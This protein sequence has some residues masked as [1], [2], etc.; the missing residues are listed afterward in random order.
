[1]ISL[2]SL[3]WLLY[4]HRILHSTLLKSYSAGT[5]WCSLF[6]HCAGVCDIIDLNP[7]S[8]MGQFPQ[9]D[10]TI[11]FSLNNVGLHNYHNK[12]WIALALLAQSRCLLGY[13]AAPAKT[14]VIWICTPYS[15]QYYHHSTKYS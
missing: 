9:A 6:I 3:A 7:K 15:V 1:M 8:R 5:A 12:A 13:R 10:F 14:H 11:F 2:T 4:G